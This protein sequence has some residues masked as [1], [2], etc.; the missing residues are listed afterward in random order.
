MD[1]LEIIK[2]LKDNP[3]YLLNL[4]IENNWPQIYQNLRSLNID[5]KATPEDV[6]NVIY[7]LFIN[8]QGDTALAALNVG[9]HAT[10]TPGYFSL[11]REAGLVPTLKSTLPVGVASPEA[12]DAE[13]SNSTFSWSNLFTSLPGILGGV[14]SILNPGYVAPGAQ[15]TQPTQTDN[16]I[17]IMV[18]IFALIILA[19]ILIA[20]FRKKK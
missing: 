8:N 17:M 13:A 14:G 12:L 6:F 2:Q 16:T 3:S 18:V 1:R 20:V 7:N 15:G 4:A 9:Y 10:N 5:V 11:I 19:V